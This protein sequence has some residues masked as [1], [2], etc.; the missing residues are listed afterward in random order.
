MPPAH[1]GEG[2]G[3]F[4]AEQAHIKTGKTALIARVVVNPTT[5]RSRPRWI[6]T[7]I[8]RQHVSQLSTN[9]CSYI[10]SLILRT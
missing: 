5:T 1:H 2:E 3:G 7:T 4:R 10:Y 8:Y 6:E 9:H